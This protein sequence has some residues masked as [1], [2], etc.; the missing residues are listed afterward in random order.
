MTGLR[1]LGMAG[2]LGATPAAAEPSLVGHWARGDGKARVV[3][4][5]CPG[6]Y[7]AIN[8]W[9]RPGTKGEKVGDK[10]VMNVSPS[11]PSTMEGKA[12]DP[13]RNLMYSMT[14]KVAAN[15]LESRG[16]IL[17]G[18]LCKNMSWSRIPG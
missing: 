14:I 8:T 4:E 2:I 12:W 7:C 17:G 9:I 5:P 3:I 10:L 18:L 13:Q 11:G 16:C 15:T 1:V 6:G